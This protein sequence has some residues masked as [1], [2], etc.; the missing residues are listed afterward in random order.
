M[1]K[2]DIIK[3]DYH[4]LYTTAGEWILRPLYGT[5]FKEGDKVKNRILKGYD[6]G[7][8]SAD[9]ELKKT[10]HFS[11]GGIYEI[12]SISGVRIFEHEA[13]T[14]DEIAERATHYENFAKTQP[15]NIEHNK[16]FEI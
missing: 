13:L 7:V 1:A 12:W 5:I 10:H 9:P 8:T 16:K 4:G 3:E 11:R 14:I 15:E 6:A 2:S